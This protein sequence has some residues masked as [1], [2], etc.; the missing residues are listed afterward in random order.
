MD[1]ITLLLIGLGIWIFYEAVSSG[2]QPGAAAPGAAQ[3]TT[4]GGGTLSAAAIAQYAAN[5]GFAGEDLLTAVAVALAESG[6][7]PT[8]VGDINITPGGSIGLWQI[9]LRWHPEYNAE[10]L[11]DPQSNANAAYAIYKAAGNSFKPWTT[12]GSGA[13]M[14][15]LDQASGFLTG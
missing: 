1:P 3:M 12:Y 2:I 6:G 8:I 7:N 10:E 5:A 4:G 9:N 13:Y 11:L 15:F 14:A